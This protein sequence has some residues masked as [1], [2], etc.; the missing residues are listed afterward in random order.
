MNKGT[1]VTFIFDHH[2]I[3]FPPIGD[4]GLLIADIAMINQLEQFD[5][6]YQ[7]NKEH[8]NWTYHQQSRLNMIAEINDNI[9]KIEELYENFR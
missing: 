8:F 5:F 3:D 6:L 7:V 9:K 4:L 2:H 1:T